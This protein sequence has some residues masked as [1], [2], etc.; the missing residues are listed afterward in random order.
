[1]EHQTEA[2]R[3]SGLFPAEARTAAI[4]AIGGITQIKEECRDMRK[5]NF[6]ENVIRDIRYAGRMFRKS[7]GFTAI[8][9]LSL[10][11]G[12]GANT[13]IFSL[14]HA[15]LM[16]DLP[17]GH[18]EQLALLT[19]FVQTGKLGD[20]ATED[21][22]D[23]REHSRSFSGLIAASHLAQID[24]GF[25]GQTETAQRKIVSG[26]YFSSLGVTT[27]L[28]RPFTNED[29]NLPVAILSDRLYQRSFGGS[30]SVLGKQVTLDGMA[31]TVIGVAPPEF[32]GEV[33]GEAPDIWASLIL[34]QAERRNQAG[35]TWLNLIGR[36]I[37]GVTMERAAAEL[38]VLLPQLHAQGRGSGFIKSVTVAP[39]GRGFSDLR[40]RFSGPLRILMVVVAVVLLIACA[41]LASLLLARAATRQ[42]EIAT[43]LAIG[44][45]RG[46]VLCQLLTESVVLALLGCGAGLLFAAWG[47]RILL[48][49]LTGGAPGGGRAI[50]L[51]L[52]PDLP[53]LLFAAAVS[54]A[55]GI[56]FGVAPA[57]QAV[58]RDVG[59]ALKLNARNLGPGRPWG[60]RNL[61][62]AAQ[63]ALCL[64][65]LVG[66][67]LFIQTLRN[68]RV[69]DAGF[70]PGNVLIV[71]FNPQRGYRPQVADLVVRLL[72]GV[73]AVPGVQAASVSFN[74]ILSDSA[75]G[76]AGLQVDGYVPPSAE[77]QRARADWVGPDYFATAGI[78][79]TEGRDFSLADDSAAQKVA[80]VNQTMAAHYFG[81]RPASGRRFQFNKEA[82]TIVGVA[83]DAKYQDLRESTPR[84]VYFAV[85]QRGGGIGAL[86]VR[87]AGSPLAFA[88]TLRTAIRQIDPRLRIGEVTTL[89]G[90]MDRKLSREYLV[91][92][93]SG[94][95]SGLTLLLVSIGIYGTLAYSVARRTSEIGI[96]MALGAQPGSVLRMVLRDILRL[97]AVGVAVGVVAVLACGPLVESMLFELKSSD[98]PTIALAALALAAT[99][100]AAGYLPAR[101]AS[102]I[103]PLTALRLE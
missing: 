23:L 7:P 37:P 60:L 63:V 6:V 84:L 99:A 14:I 85:L 25:A 69:Q 29:E 66:G 74:G 97:L 91:A 79:L 27:A 5:V 18:P 40:E 73:K 102:R 50:V 92:D 100:L 95:F 35:I 98:L 28:G 17:V 93:I 86:D 36:L 43:R 68:L 15:V 21:Y 71:Q 94:F 49:L 55:T 10:A 44:A 4:R 34:G 81:N 9:V 56:L 48:A 59:P 87:T 30:P 33:V 76:V 80:I 24:V 64:F 103:D 89:S 42:R 46:R 77:D 1:M 31:F 61:L 57:L 54:L 11:L 82:Y 16:R 70:H 65:L 45:A 67:G 26:N 62:V 22:L 51:D 52:R 20:F 8:A 72:Q 12:I 83:K 2:L 41:N 53:V 75:S 90:R 78:P 88:G 38:N 58:R 3:A 32:L 96:R 13:A 101:R 39:G 47:V 19:S